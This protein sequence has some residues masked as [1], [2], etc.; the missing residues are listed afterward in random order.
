[1]VAMSDVTHL[2]AETGSARG[3]AGD[4][5]PSTRTPTQYPFQNELSAKVSH[6]AVLDE[7]TTVLKAASRK[8]AKSDISSIFGNAFCTGPLS[9][10]H[11]LI[12]TFDCRNSSHPRN[13]HTCHGSNH[14]ARHNSV[15][16][17]W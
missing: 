14:K 7:Q 8:A 4:P 5:H 6:R 3:H 10:G 17:P 15:G 13:T 1:M 2:M 9:V 12:L 16:Y 11:E